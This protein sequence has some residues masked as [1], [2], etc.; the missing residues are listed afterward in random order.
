LAGLLGD[1][2][3]GI[4]Q[5]GQVIDRAAQSAPSTS[6]SRIRPPDSLSFAGCAV[7]AA[8]CSAGVDQQLLRIGGGVVGQPGQFPGDPPDHRLRLVAA[9]RRA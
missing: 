9:L 2:S 3:R 4:E 6:R 5:P 8:Q 1:S 7:G